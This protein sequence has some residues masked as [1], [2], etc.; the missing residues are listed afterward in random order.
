VPK[1][2]DTERPYWRVSREER[3]VGRKRIR[4]NWGWKSQPCVD[5]PN[6]S[7]DLVDDGWR[8]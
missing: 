8:N 6:N 7:G 5:A 1:K 3:L 2:K 4:Y